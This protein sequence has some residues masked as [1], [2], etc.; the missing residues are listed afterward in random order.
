ML[1]LSMWLLTLLTSRSSSKVVKCCAPSEIFLSA[2][3]TCVEVVDKANIWKPTKAFKVEEGQLVELSSK[4]MANLTVEGSF[5]DGFLNNIME[6]CSDIFE[7]DES[8]EWLLVEGGLLHHQ[9]YG[10]A[11]GYCVDH[12]LHPDGKVDTL[13]LR[14]LE[15]NTTMAKECLNTQSSHLLVIFTVLGVISLVFLLVTLVVYVTVPDL[16]N[17][18]G[19]I[20]IGKDHILTPR[21]GPSFFLGE[22]RLQYLL[23]HHLSAHCLQCVYPSRYCQC[24]LQL[25]LVIF[26]TR[27]SPKARS[28]VLSLATRATTPAWQCLLG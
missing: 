21:E 1:L 2:S 11:S 4:E 8:E 10:L 26:S 17:L 7:L 6:N 14:C 25:L 28:P 18:H 16:F 15:S 9:G 24:H 23:G 3:S 27:S 19:K 20:V 22:Q 13:V 12:E 5:L